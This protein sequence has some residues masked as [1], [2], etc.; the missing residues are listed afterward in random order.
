MLNY[1]KCNSKKNFIYNLD[2]ILVIQLLIGYWRFTIH[3]AYALVW[4]YSIDTRKN[5][6]L[7]N[8]NK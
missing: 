7:D 2:I 6:K 4:H 1:Y 8:K 5:S 3:L